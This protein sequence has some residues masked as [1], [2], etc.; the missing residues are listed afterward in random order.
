[1]PLLKNQK[2]LVA[3]SDVHLRLCHPLYATWLDAWRLATCIH[4]CAA[5]WLYV[6]LVFLAA[7]ESTLPMDLSFWYKVSPQKQAHDGFPSPRSVGLLLWI[8][9]STAH[10]LEN[11]FRAPYTNP[12]NSWNL[13][14]NVHSFASVNLIVIAL[15]GL[16]LLDAQKLRCACRLLGMWATAS[17]WAMPWALGEEAPRT[18]S[19]CCSNQGFA[20]P[21]S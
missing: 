8:S 15:L 11:Y 20:V 1:M 14:L 13:I 12:E 9:S 21:T 18:S 16:S 7:V 19:L 6:D 10:W 5:D 17:W 3:G 4:C 2:Q